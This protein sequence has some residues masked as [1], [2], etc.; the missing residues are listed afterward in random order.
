MIPPCQW[1]HRSPRGAYAARASPRNF[2]LGDGFM[3]IG[4]PN[5][6][7][8]KIQFLLAFRP[9]HFENVGKC[10]MFIRYVSRKI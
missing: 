6:P 4:H 2:L 8:P 10:K 5:P 7:T 3:G 1:S 9:L